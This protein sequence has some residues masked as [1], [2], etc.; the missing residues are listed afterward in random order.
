MKDCEVFVK[1]SQ[2][3][4]VFCDIFVKSDEIY[5]CFFEFTF[6]IGDRLEKRGRSEK[7]C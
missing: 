3:F 5:L 7:S 6:T 2:S 4:C 1:I